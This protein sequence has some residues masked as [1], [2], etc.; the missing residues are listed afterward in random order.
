MEGNLEGADEADMF[1]L[2]NFPSASHTVEERLR[3]EMDFGERVRLAREGRI[4]LEEAA[5]EATGPAREAMLGPEMADVS[6][7]PR[8]PKL[9]LQLKPLPQVYLPATR[10]S[11]IHPPTPTAPTAHPIHP[12]QSL[13]HM[14]HMLIDSAT[15]GDGGRHG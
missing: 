7:G 15:G 12:Y 6:W 5:K 1:D 3:R 14:T 8:Q 2:Y 10:P 9:K 11:K 4:A 13:L